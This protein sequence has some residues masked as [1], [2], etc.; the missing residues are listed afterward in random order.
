MTNNQ[1]APRAFIGFFDD[2]S[3]GKIS[4]WA[5][6]LYHS[7]PVTLHLLID[8]QEVLQIVCDGERPDVQDNLKLSHNKVGF[9]AFIPEKFFDGK[10]HQLSLRFPDRSVLPFTDLDN[11]EN[12][13]PV[14]PFQGTIR[15][16]YKSFIDGIKQGALRGWVLRSAGPGHDFVGKCTIAITVNGVRLTQ[17]RADRYRGD[18][19]AAT[20]HDPNCGFEVPIPQHLRGNRPH[21]FNVVALP[22]KEELNGSPFTTTLADDALESRLVD[23]LDVIDGLHKQITTLRRE[24]KDLIP[25]RGHNLGDYDRWAR[26]YY[27]LLRERTIKKRQLNSSQK[28]P[29]VSVLCPTYRPL[30]SDF[31]AAINSVVSQTYTNW[32]LIIIDDA[33]KSKETTDIIK[34]F[35]KEDKRIRAIILE[36]NEGISG[37]TN[38]GMDAA[39]GDYVVFFD[40]DDLLVDVALETMVNAALETGAK[41]LYSDE[42]KIDQAGYFLEPNLKP[43]YNY[44]YLLGCNYICHITMVETKLMRQIGSLRSKYDGAQ[45]HDFVLRAVEILKPEEIHHVPEI[46]YHW[47][48]TPNSTAVNVSNKTY[49]IEAGIR[50]VQDHLD[51][52]KVKS[53][54]SSIRGLTLYGVQWLTRKTPKVTIIIPFKDQV[55]T[56]RQC[57]ETLFERTKY[58]AFDIL[59]VNNWSIEEET[60]SFIKDIEKHPKVSVLTVE[61]PF[62]YSRLNNLAAASTK[63]DYLFFMNNDVF[64]SHN[65]WLN[66]A[67]GEALAAPDVAAVGAKLLYPNDT[68]QHAGVAVGPAGIGAHVHRGDPLSEYGY[69]GRTMLTH[70]VTAVTA[71]AMLVKSSV[72][73]EVGGF[74]EQ[75][76]TVAYNDVDLCL[77]IR[78]AGYRIIFSA[79]VIAYHHE[80]LSRGSDDRP[81]HETRFFHETQTMLTRWSNNPLFERDPAYPRYFTVDQQPFFD[82]IDPEKL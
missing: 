25:Q 7:E 43:D 76:L 30:S 75:E 55:D 20:G 82:L 27:P 9:N 4:G 23:L 16:Q 42:D 66:I 78:S 47:R 18:V 61:E 5:L 22:D 26:K 62:N 70:D 38:A 60:L 31:I 13:L 45:D 77:K 68:I 41:L 14:I 44:R 3:N 35:T 56:T 33:G 65:D 11:P 21:T 71:A 6:S 72:F 81:E 50:C 54:V 57:V 29:L 36:K 12:V 37:A 46:L 52:C 79:E 73:H 63:A 40:H 24:V 58:K 53:K 51:R 17:S 67:I 28:T 80:S 69:I 49:A 64:V 74:D 59:L 15:P 1:P 48:K 34:K 10:Q 19:A 8:Q 39:K 32:E 2:F